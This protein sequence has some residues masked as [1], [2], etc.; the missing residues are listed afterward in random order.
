MR[1]FIIALT[2]LGMALTSCKKDMLAAFTGNYTDIFIYPNPAG[3]VASRPAWITFNENSY[4]STATE[5]TAPAGSAN[6]E[7]P[8]SGA[9]KFQDHD[10][11]TAEFDWGLFLNGEYAYKT[12]GDRLFLAKYIGGLKIFEYRLEKIHQN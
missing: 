8:D 5:N 11:W 7:I 12:H 9:I 10:I 3:S 1:R 6:F 4:T 2:I